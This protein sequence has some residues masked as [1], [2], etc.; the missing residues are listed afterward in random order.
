M[1][2]NFDITKYAKKKSPNYR[3]QELVLEAFSSFQIKPR[4]QKMI[5]GIVGRERKKNED[6]T[7]FQL[8]RAIRE[9]Q[10]KKLANP[11]RYFTKLLVIFLK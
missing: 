10:N 2:L 1:E 3:F 8:E 6:F 9:T 5:W 7:L 11:D 4:W